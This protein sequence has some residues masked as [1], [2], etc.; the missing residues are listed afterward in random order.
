M[1]TGVQTCALPICHGT[2]SNGRNMIWE[3]LDNSNEE[4]FVLRQETSRSMP[5]RAVVFQKKGCSHWYIEVWN[6]TKMNWIE[7]DTVYTDLIE[8]KAV[9]TARAAMDLI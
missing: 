4:G 9:A 7:Q 1:V 3:P 2:G 5:N 8:A 6:D